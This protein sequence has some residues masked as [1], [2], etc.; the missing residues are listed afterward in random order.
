[1]AKT[2]KIEHIEPKL[3]KVPLTKEQ[4]TQAIREFHQRKYLERIAELRDQQEK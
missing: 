3:K 1:M 2:K 4:A